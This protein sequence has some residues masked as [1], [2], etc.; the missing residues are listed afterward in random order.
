METTCALQLMLPTDKRNPSFTLYQEDTA[1]RIHV[2]YGMELLQVV[3]DDRNHVQYKLLVANLYNAGLRVPTLESLFG[4]DR[5]TM[6]VWGL[7]LQS[8]QVERLARALE[9]R[10]RLRKLTPEIQ[11]FI[12]HRFAEVYSQH[13]R[14]YNIQLRREVQA[15]FGV[16][17]S[18][19]AIRP[20]LGTLRAAV[21]PPGSSASVSSRPAE[22][23]VA[24]ACEL[25]TEPELPP[26]G[27]K[28]GAVAPGVGTVEQSCEWALAG[29]ALAPATPK[30]IPPTPVV[31]ALEPGPSPASALA[32]EEAGAETP[33][34]PAGA[35]S[36]ALGVE[37]PLL[38]PSGPVPLKL[39]PPI[40]PWADGQARWCDHL[41]LLL[42]WQPL[43]Q[44]AALLTPPTPWLKQW[45]ASVLLG[46]H[47]V[48]QTKYLNWTELN[49][50]L[51]PVVA[52]PTLQ[53]HALSQLATSATVQA[54]WRWNAQQVA[55][56]GESDF[57]LDPHTKHYTG[58]QPILKGWC[59]V[60]RWADKALHSDFVH[61]Q[62]GEA[63]YCECTDN[64][65]DLRQRLWDLVGRLRQTLGWSA[66]KVLTLVVDRG[67]FGL[68]VFEKVLAEPGL[69]LITWEKGYEPGQW[70]ES[71]KQGE[72]IIER[73][74]NR[75]EDVRT[76]HFKYLER[77]WAKAPKMRQLIV[78]ATNPEG[79]SVEVGVLT[80]D[81]TRPAREAL[82]LIFNRWL[83]ENDFKYADKHFGINQITSYRTVPYEELKGKLQDR[84]VKSG[85]AKALSQAR[86]GLERQQK[87]Y[88]FAQ[89]QADVRH[90][91]RQAVLAEWEKRAATPSGQA[92]AE[93]A[94]AQARGQAASQR[95]EAHRA[96]RRQKI[97]ALQAQ[98]DTNRQQW[99][100]VAKEESR[101]E[102]LIAQGMQRL[103]T[104][105]KQLM[106]AI[107]VAASN[108]FRQALKPFKEAY[109]NYRDDHD[110]FRQLTHSGG[111]LRWT[112]QTFEVH[113]L[114]QVNHPPALQA[115]IT[116]LLEQLNATQPHLPDGSQR[117]L[118]FSLS[119]RDA[120]E[121]RLK[122]VP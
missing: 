42:F 117:P 106:D 69:H 93:G 120:F 23:E 112:G 111:V 75:A 118:K 56:L 83:Q 10:Q 45:L 43:S 92:P 68:E 27:D 4:V 21:S 36:G 60:I 38:P 9:G 86:L 88:L 37:R 18:G 110:H 81:P 79:K 116:T 41:G 84:Q 32:G 28:A 99:A 34:V 119:D 72:F 50:L 2:Y 5:K 65:A 62:R 105:T 104:R 64:F 15:V 71:G 66:D 70:Q 103:D 51:G 53:R 96:E 25:G 47:N 63:I 85:Q 54:V 14:A 82:R 57:Y 76:Y 59:P 44:V 101:L 26:P 40:K 102:Q 35:N 55:A 80:D 115:I 46:A 1:H 20:L 95:Y 13:P 67:I 100:T 31:A 33:A 48:E 29:A 39:P 16:R 78:V 58:Q 98:L 97:Q 6:R 11:S 24:P 52:V 77:P 73:S 89:E 74:R 90:A 22:G 49:V 121:I 107:K 113:L 109:D 87:R 19:E 8:G 94:K 3:P 91:R 61:T 30:L 122:K 17:L 12:R 108:A 114:P 7:A